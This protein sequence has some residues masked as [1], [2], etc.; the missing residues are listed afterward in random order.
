MTYLDE[1]IAACKLAKSAC[2]TNEIVLKSVEDIDSTMISGPAVYVIEDLSN[3]LIAT[4]QKLIQY[5]AT[6]T[7]KCPKINQP[8]KTMYVGSSQ[9]SVSKR[10]KQHIGYGPRQ[11][12]AL[13]LSFWFDGDFK[14]RILTYDVSAL[15]LQLVEDDLSH[16]LRPAFGKRGSNNRM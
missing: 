10:L 8:S 12:Y 14:I 6:S 9:S 15:V 7:R 11:T 5:K 1:L 3:D 13:N 16:R 4:H 2:P